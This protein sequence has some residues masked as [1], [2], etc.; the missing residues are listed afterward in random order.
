MHTNN[1]GNSAKY[2]EKYSESSEMKFLIIPIQE[3]CKG[4]M[5]DSWKKNYGNQRQPFHLVPV[6]DICNR[7]VY[8]NNVFSIRI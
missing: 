8:Q 1:C 7:I 6:G 3:S 2:S 4:S 5:L